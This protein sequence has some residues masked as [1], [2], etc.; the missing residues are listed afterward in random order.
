MDPSVILDL[1]YLSIPPILVIYSI[2]MRISKG[3]NY[4]Q[5]KTFYLISFA[6]AGL[7]FAMTLLS[8]I[9]R[10]FVMFDWDGIILL[11]IIISPFT[12][13]LGA[14]TAFIHWKNREA[15]SYSGIGGLILNLL[16]I[17]LNVYMALTVTL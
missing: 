10:I 16:G 9:I 12:F 1:I 2:A 15:H 6:F 7:P 13:I 5:S 11:A 4:Y 3:K 14:I 17:T 8:F